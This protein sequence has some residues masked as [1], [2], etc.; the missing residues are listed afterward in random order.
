[1]NER[2]LISTVIKIGSYTGIAV[3]VAAALLKLTGAGPGGRAGAV[4]DTLA[5]LSIVILVFTPVAAMLL[6]A[7]YFSY[8]REW[9][10]AA[11]AACL[12]VL[13]LLSMVLLR[14]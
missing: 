5:Y 1:M 7:V 6:S 3:V 11:V 2:K 12:C 4:F 9:R 14:A 13:I 10:W 8:R